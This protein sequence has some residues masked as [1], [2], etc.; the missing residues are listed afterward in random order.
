M[1]TAEQIVAE[2]S[3]EEKVAMMHGDPEFWPGIVAFVAADSYHRSPFPAGCDVT[4][5]LPGLRFVDGP[6]GLVIR[7]GTTFPVTMAR[8]AAWDPELEARI[9][10]AIGKEVRAAG[11]NLYGGVCVNLLRHPGWGRAQ[12]TYGEDPVQLAELGMALTRGV[13]RH[14]LATVKHFALNSMED[15]RF[16]VDVAASPRVLH[17]LYLPHFREIVESGVHCVMSAYN[18][19]NGEWCGQSPALLRRILKQDWGFEGFVISDFVFGLR[20]AAE[21]AQAGLDLEMPFGNVY[22]SHLVDL[23]QRGE[24]AEDLV[25]ES[26]VRLARAQLALPQGSWPPEL[27]GCRAHREL[28]REAAQKSIVLLKNDDE[29]LPLEPTTRVALLGRLAGVANLG[30]KGSSDGR[31]P[32]A[33][34]PRE[35]MEA[36]GQVRT[37][38]SDDPDACAAA[39]RDADVAVVVVGFTEADEGESLLPPDIMGIG[40]GFPPPRPLSWFALGHRL[41]PA[42]ARPLTRLA[43]WVVGR[44]SG[45]G[46]GGDR[47]DLRLRPEHEALIAAVVAAN[48]RTLVIIEAGSAVIMESWRH[49][50]PGILMLWYPGMEGGHAL[51]DVVFGAVPPGGRMPVSTPTEPAHLPAWDPDA[52]AVRYDLWHGYRKL[53]R[54]GQA[55]AFPLGFGLSTTRFEWAR[56]SASIDGARLTVA[57]DVANVG[58]RDGDDVVQLYFALPD[59]RFERPPRQLLAFCRV[60]AAAGEQVRAELSAPLRRLA[61]F[62]EAL[63]DFVLEGGPLALFLARHAEDPEPLTVVLDLPHRRTGRG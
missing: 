10:D 39:A 3:L 31:P 23:V 24:V 8:G 51:A 1:R 32:Y 20:D 28:A 46:L 53:A 59:S 45:F 4:P 55:A 38:A 54:D 18:S 43:R 41:W 25:T 63:D 42:I 17:E 34:S 12:E 2:L 15:M 14:A 62:D 56:P 37:V 40:D 61:A 9:G 58:P 60:H 47:R 49:T 22:R 27:I 6:R 21:G 33:V 36:A 48:P 30:D 13:Q 44:F 7:G 26:A 57:V 5:E 52:K 11:A 35:G 16:D 29:L 50:V 19:L